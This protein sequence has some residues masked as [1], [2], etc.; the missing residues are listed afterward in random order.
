MEGRLAEKVLF[1]IGQMEIKWNMIVADITDDV[2]Q[3]IYV[4]EHQKT[5]IKLTEYSIELKG[6][7]IP[8][9]VI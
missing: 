9:K 7:K 3:G 1:R 5:V 2:I 4:L 6:E 8:S